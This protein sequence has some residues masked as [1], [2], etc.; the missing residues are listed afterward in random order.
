MDNYITI[1]ELSIRKS[2]AFVV[3]SDFNPY[4]IRDG[5]IVTKTGMHM[6]MSHVDSDLRVHFPKPYKKKPSSPLMLVVNNAHTFDSAAQMAMIGYFG[7]G[8]ADVTP[9]RS[10]KSERVVTKEELKILF[11]EPVT[12][13]D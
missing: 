3:D 9:L 12:V 11:G 10:E 5:F 8:K 7:R 1:K 4:F 6:A 13:A 2:P